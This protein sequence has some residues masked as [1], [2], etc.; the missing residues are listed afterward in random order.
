MIIDILFLLVAGWGFYQGYSRGIIKTVFT[1]FSIVF[2]LMIAFKFTPAAIRF[3]ETAFHSDSALNFIGGFLLVFILTMIIIRMAAQFIEKML[4]TANINFINQ[5]AG[6]ILLAAL[7]TLVYSLLIWFGDQSHIIT[8]EN[9]KGS[10]T[11]E[12]LR[13]FPSKMKGVYEY[14]KPGF[15]DF[16]HESVRFID[17]M[18]DK[19]LKETEQQ[20]TIFDIPD[21]GETKTDSAK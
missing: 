12:Q 18:E 4:Q 17:R 20:P 2:G 21:E 8:A 16:W 7:H 15:Q 13:A 6:G 11:Y 5:A 19:S 3:L 1:A 10:M 9:S 14:I